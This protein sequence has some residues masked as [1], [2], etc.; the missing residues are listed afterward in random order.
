MILALLALLLGLA[1]GILIGIKHAKRGQ[2]I[3]DA[4][5]G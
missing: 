3:K 1:A 5:K 4:I 2:A